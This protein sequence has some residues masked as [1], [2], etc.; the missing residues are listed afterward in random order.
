MLI[1]QFTTLT[2]TENSQDVDE[3]GLFPILH[4]RLTIDQTNSHLLSDFCRCVTSR[5]HSW[6]CKSSVFTSTISFHSLWET[7]QHLLDRMLP[8]FVIGLT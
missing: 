2:Q 7:S 5:S 8:S 4:P 3:S 1:G 6:L